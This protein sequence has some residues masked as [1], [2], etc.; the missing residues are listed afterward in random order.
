MV[1]RIATE[2]TTFRPVFEVGS[3]FMEQAQGVEAR[4]QHAIAPATVDFDFGEISRAA[5]GIPDS[6]TVKIIRGWGLQ[7]TAPVSVMV[8]SLREAVRQALPQPF[9]NPAFWEKV[10]Q[11][12]TDAF[13]GLHGQTGTHLSFYREDP[14]N[15]SYYYNVLFALQDEETDDSL[16]A[17]AFCANVTVALSPEEVRTLTVEDTAQ[18]TIRLNAI[19]VQRKLPSAG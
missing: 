8:L 7:E 12:L 17:V 6:S 9:A 4:F 10:E 13:V 16:Y 5:S 11:A 15:T 18:Y 1:D 19:T 14:D 3:S 2:K